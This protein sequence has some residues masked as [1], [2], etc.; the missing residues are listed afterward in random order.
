MKWDAERVSIAG[1]GTS[2]AS[3]S[4]S[5]R[6][7]LQ[8]LDGVYG[9]KQKALKERTDPDVQ[10]AVKKVQGEEQTMQKLYEQWKALRDK[11]PAKPKQ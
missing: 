8:D 5:T 7:R 10:E 11:L 1:S 9:A 6:R 4:A 3:I 2:N